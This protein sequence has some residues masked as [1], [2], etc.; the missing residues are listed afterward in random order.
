[1]TRKQN[2]FRN[3]FYRGFDAIFDTLGMRPIGILVLALSGFAALQLVGLSLDSVRTEAVATAKLVEHPSRVESFV[4]AVF[5][6]AGDRVEVGSPLVELSPHFIDQQLT[7]LALEAEQL[8]NEKRLEQ[9]RLIVREER[10]LEPGVRV[11]P[12]RPSLEAPTEA[13]YAKQLEVV[14]ARRAALLSDREALL[15]HSSF[16]GVVSRVAGLG[17]SIGEGASVASVAPEYADEIVAYVP[18]V[19]DAASISLESLAFIVDAGS[20]AC[21]R[22]GRVRSRGAAVEQAPGQLTQLLRGPLHG[23]PVHV[24]VPTGCRLGIGQVLSLDLRAGG[25]NS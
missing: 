22:P 8:I 4:T 6:Q 7:Q 24:E 19:T 14:H 9:A 13:Y 12:S 25:R 2:S 15:I 18:A 20:D 21:R 10:W 16:S 23:M 17:T 11:R 1:M 3:R 5:V